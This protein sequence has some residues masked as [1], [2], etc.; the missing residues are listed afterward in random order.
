MALLVATSTDVEAQITVE[1]RILDVSSDV[2]DMDPVGPSDPMWLYQIADVPNTTT[3]NSSTFLNATNCP[4]TVNVNDLFFTTVYNCDAPTSFD[5][6]WQGYEQDGA[7]PHDA[8]TGPQVVNIP[9]GSLTFPQGAWTTIG[10]YNTTAAGTVGCPGVAGNVTW[11]VVLQYRTVGTLPP[12]QTNPTI[13]CPADQNVNLNASCLYSVVDF[14]GMAVTADACSPLVVTQDVAVGTN[15]AV[16]TTITLTVTDPT[17]NSNTCTFD[18]I[19]ADNTNP[20]I[21]C[22]G[23]V[24]V[25]NDPGV[26]NANV[27]VP[28]PATSDN[29]GVASVIN[30]YNSTASADDNYPVGTT[31]VTW[32]VTDVNGN[33][34]TCT[35]D[36]TV[37]DNENPTI[38]CDADVSVNNDPGV[39]NAAV[40]VGAPVATAD[41]CGIAS[42]LNDFNGTASANDTYPVGT[43]TVTWTITDVNGNTNTCTQ[44]VTVTDNENP[45][46]TCDADVTVNNDA[47][48]CNAVVAVPV[49]TA[50]GDNC[51]VATV[52]NDY[53]GTASAND[54]YPV[55]TTTV[56]WEVTDIH[57]NTQFCT[58]DVTV[59][60]AE[61]PTI[62]CDA[63]VTVNNDAGVCDAAV[64]VGAPVTTTD[65]CGV[66]TVL[67]DFNGTASANDT[68][69]VGTTTVT[70]TVTDVNGNTNTCTQ[71]VT[72]N[73]TE[74]P[75][76]TCSAD[77]TQTADPG[78]CNAA[79]I[80][81][82]PSATGD[83]CG[84]A[85]VIN[86]YN[87]TASADDTYP[88]GTTTVTWTVTDVNGNTNT[89]T[90]DVTVTDN[91][92]PTITCDADVTVNNDV[93][94]CNANVVVPPPVATG[95]NCG[96]ATVLN[97]YN[98]TASANDTYPVGTTTVTWEVTDLSGNTQFCTQDVTVNDTENPTITCDADVTV[99]NDVGVCNANV[100]VPPPIATG[101]NC[102]VATVLNDYNGTASANDTYPVGT[103]TVTWTVTDLSGNTNTCTQDV[104]V[105]D[106][107][108]PTITCS[109]DVTQTADPGVCNAAVIVP[110]PSATGDNCGVA[111]V[112]NDYNGTASAD[113][114]YP[115]GTTTVT[116][117][118]TDVNG[119]TNTCTQDVTV[120][121]N[122]NPTITCD[123]DV[124]VNN[125][126]GV[127]NAN[128][129]VP[130]P[131]ATGD[132]CGVATVLNDYNGTAS[133]NDNYPV[134]TT[135]V[136]WEVTDLSGNTQTCTQDVTVTDNENPT[137]TCAPD[138]AVNN[139]PGVCNAAVVVPGPTTS[140]NCGVATVI[141]DYNGTASADDTYPVG[142]TTVT[143]TV[144]D[145]HG[146]VNTCTQDVTVNDNEAPVVT[147]PGNVAQNTDAGVCTAVVNGIDMVATS[148]NC[149][150]ILQTWDLTGATVA[151]SPGAG[152][153]D[154]S[155]QTFNVGTTTV[156]YTIE[157]AVGNQTTCSFDVVITDNELP[158]I[159]CPGN[160]NTTA[161][162]G[163]CNT[164]VN[165]IAPV[166]TADNCG[167]VLQT[168]DLTGATVASSPGVGIN[169]ASGQTFNVG[170]TTVTYTVEDASGNSA[171]CSFDVTVTDTEIPSITCGANVTVN[172]D[173]GV[174]N[175]AVI[176]PAPATNDNCGVATVINDYNGTASAN[177]TYPVGTTTITW[178]VT[179]VNGNVNTCTQDVTVNDNENPTISC[180][181][182]VA[183]NID[184]GTCGAVVNVIAPTSTG[185]NCGIVTQTWDLTGATVASSPGAGIN[186][187]SGQTFNVGTTTVTYTVTDAAGNTATCSF[188]VVITDN[189]NPTITCPGNVAQNVDPGNCS[190]VVNA[191]APTATADNCGVIIQTWDLTGATV[192]SSPAAGI[193]DASGQTFNVGT[194]TVTYTV[195]DA[196]GN[197]A[198]CS[199]DVVIT[200]N[201]NPTI[202][203]PGNVN[204]NNDPGNCSAVVNGL[205]P[206]AT[207]DNCGITI[208]T[209][210]ITGVTTA[211]SPL[212][213]INDASGQTFNVGASVVTY[214]VEDAA[215]NTA[216]CNFTVTVF[217]NENPTIT[218]PANVNQG[219]DIGNCSAVVTGI[220]PVATNDNCG[221]IIQTWDLTGATVAS[222]PA[223][224]INDASGETF[225][226]GT[227][228]VTYTVEDAAGNTATCSFDVTITD[229]ENPTVVSCPANINQNADPGVCTATFDPVDP[230]FSDNCG[231][232]TVTWA[233]T[234]ASTGNS[235][236]GGIN[237]VGNTTYNL[238]TST[239]TYTV[240]DAVGNS[241]TCSFDI[242]II[243]A[244]APTITCPAN[245]TINND[246]GQCNAVV[247]G[248]GPIATGDNCGIDTQTWTLTGATTANSPATGINDASGQTFNLGTT[249]VTYTVTDA[250]GNATS[251]SF[252]ITIVDAENPVIVCPADITQPNNPGVCGRTITYAAPIGTDNC[253]GATTT[254]I[255]GLAS[256]SLF[257]IGTTVVTYEV[258]DAAGNTAQCSF[259]VTVNDTENPSISCPADITQ[260]SDPGICGATVTYVAPVGADNCPGAVTSLI[261]G[262][263]SGTIF[264]TGTTVV[265]Y[266]VVDA[267]GNTAQCSFNVTINDNED[268]TIACP[269]DITVSNDAGVCGA[270]VN[271]AAPVT[272]DNCPGETTTLIAGLA[273]GSV[274]PIGTTVVTYEV[275]DASGNTAQ[276]SFNVTVDD[277]ENPVINCPANI[278]QA[279][280][281]GLCGAIITYA[282][283]VGTD[284]CPG[285]VTTMTAGQASGTVFSVGTTTVTYQVTDASGNTAQCSFDV[286]VNDTQLPVINC[287][288]N[289]TQPNNPGVCGRT[290]TYG[291]PT[292]TDNC[293]G[294]V[295]TLTTGL[296]SGS[297]FPIG[298]TTVTYEVTDASGNT[299][300][301][302]FDVTINDTENP[303]ISCP[304]NITQAN[305]PGL[306]GAV[307]NY[308]TPVGADNCPGQT[309]TLIAGLASGSVFPV[310]TTTV[311]YEV[312]DASGN[313]AQCSFDV[314]VNDTENPTINCPADIV[315]SNDVGVCGAIVNY[316]TP[317]GADNCPGSV[318]TMTAGLATGSLFPIGTTV[319]TYQVT[320]ASGNTATCSFNVTVDD[321]E[322]PVIACP[323]DITQ[324]NDPALCGAVVTY[325]PPVGTDNCPGAVTTLI[326]GQAS[327]TV[328]PIGTTVVTY[329]VTDASGNTAQC[330]F[331]VTV[332]DTELPTITCPSNITQTN[333]PGVCGRT[334]SYGTPTGLDNCPGAT[335]T[336]IAGLASGSLF[337]IGTTTVTYEVTDA[338]GNTA[339]CSFD[340]TI[341]DTENPTIS[342]PANITQANDPAL[343]GAVVNYVTPVGADNC[344]GSVTSL[345]AGQASGTV[346]TV[347]TTTV[348]YEVID[349]SG[350]TAQC[351]FDITVQDTENPTINCPADIIVGNDA[352]V[353]GAIVNYATP[354]GLDNCPGS[355]TILTGGLA[356]GSLFPIGTTTVSYQVTDAS[357]NTANCSFDVTVDDTENPV[358]ACPANITQSNDPGLCGATVVYATPVGTDNCPGAVTVMTA[359]QASG[360]VFPI[361]TTTV[362]YQVTDASGNTTQCSFNV[363]VNDNENPVIVCPADMTV[364]NDPG[365]CGAIVNY[366]AP[367]GVDNCPGAATNL[368]AGLAPG[369][370]FPIGTTTVTYEVVDAA[371]NSAQCSFD[372]TVN[373]TEN[374][375]ISCPADITTN[376]ILNVCGAVV[377]YVTPVGTDNCPGAV[378]AMTT[379]LTSGALFPV[380]TTVVTYQVT[381]AAGN[382]AQCSFNVTVNDTQN[383]TITC[384]ANISVNN[385]PGVC[386]AIV[387]FVP[388]GGGDNCPGFTVNLIAGLPP[389]SLFPIGTTTVTYEVTDASGNTNQCSFDVTVNDNEFPVIT[390]PPNIIVNNDPGICGAVVNY[391]APVGTDNCPGAVTVLTAGL[392]PG[393][394]FP[395]GTTTVTYEVTD[396]SGN[397]S[398]CSFD[399]TVNDSEL[400]TI[401]CPAN[402][403]VSNDIGSCGAIVNYVTPVG[404]D[405]C[406]GSVTSLI[407]GLASGSFFPVGTTTVTYEVVDASGNTAQCSFDVTVQD[408]ENPAISCPPDITV[409]NDPGVCGAVVNYLAPT[410][411]DN[412]PGATTTL[413]AGQASGTLFPVGTTIV[414]Y[415]VTDAAGNSVTCSFNVIVND[416][417][418][419]IIACPGNINVFNDPGVCGANV[420]YIP[421]VGLDNCPGSVTTLI[422]GLPPGSFFPVGTTTITYEVVD[423][424]GN[425][426]QCSFDIIVTDN[427]PA[428]PT[429]PPDTTVYFDGACQ[430]LL[431]NYVPLT[432]A[433]DNCGVLSITQSPPPGTILLADQ[434]V[435]MT[436]TDVNGNVITC[437]FNVFVADSTSP[438]ISC[439][440]DQNV[441]FDASC[442]YILPDYTGL[443]L[444]G[445]N[446][447]AVT[448][449]QNPIAGTAI[450]DTTTITLTADDGNGNT[451]TCTFDVNPSDNIN[452]VITCPGDQNVA[453][454]ANCEYTLLDYTGL[455]IYSDNC[456]I[457]SVTQSL[458]AGTV[459][460]D[461]VTITITVL[462]AA[463]NSANCSFDVNPS[464]Q[465]IPTIACPPT[466]NVFFD[467]N[468][469]YTL[470]D[471]TTLP[472][473]SDNCGPLTVTQ[474]PAAGT[475][476]VVNTTVTLTVTDAAGNFS[477]CSFNVE[478]TD[479]IPPVVT[480][481]ADQIVSLSAFCDYTMPNMTPLAS[482][483][484]NCGIGSITQDIPVGTV[485]TNTTLVTI[486]ATDLEGNTDQCNFQV[487]PVDDTPPI[488]TCPGNQNV[489]FN[490]SCQYILLDYT[491][492]T[493]NSDN[494][495]PI[496]LNQTPAP[497]T[498]ITDTTT[499]TITATDAAGNVTSCNFDVNPSD[500]TPPVI[501]S[502]PPDQNEYVGISCKYTIP[503][504]TGLLTAVDNCGSYTVTQFPLGGT[505]ISNNTTITLTATDDNGNSS[506]CTFDVLLSDTISPTI[507]CPPAPVN[508][509]FDVNCE[510]IIVP[511]DSLTSPFDNCI[512]T[513]VSQVPPPGTAI[514]GNQTMTMIVTDASGN[515]GQCMFDLIPQD[516]IAPVI[517]CPGNQV[518]YLN[519]TCHA[520]I[521]DYTPLANTTANCE[522]VIVTQDP[523]AGT[524]VSGQ[525][526]IILY[527]E[528]ASGNQSFC[529]FNMT[530]TDTIDPVITCPP[531][532]A[533]CNNVVLFSIPT[534]TDNCGPVTVTRISGLPSGS[535]FP[536]GITTQTYVAEDAYG[537]TDTCSFIIEVYVKPEGVTAVTQISCYGESDGE[538][539]LEVIAG[540]PPFNY[541]W[542]NGA[543]T[544]DLTGLVEG[545]YTC[546]I[547]GNYGCSDT[548]T[549]DIIEP[550]SLWID[551]TITDI[552]CFGDGDGNVFVVVNGGT[553]PYSYTWSPTGAGNSAQNLTPGDYTLTV[554]DSRGCNVTETYTVNEPDSITINADISFYP[555]SGY[556]ISFE[557]GSDG[558][559]DLDVVGGNGPP[560]A[561]SWDNGET[562]DM[563]EDLMAGTYTVI[564]IDTNGCEQTGT[565]ILEEPLA[566][567][568]FTGL[569]PN[570][571]GYNDLWKILN[572]ERYP[573]NRLI[574]MNRWGNVVYEM[575][576]YAHT[577]GVWDD[578]ASWDGTPNKGIVMYGDKVPEGSYYFVFEAVKG[579]K[580]RYTGY[581]VVKY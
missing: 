149:G 176:V 113:D 480:C 389:G 10:T 144:T 151:S 448:V 247:N 370:F 413:I 12:D 520:V 551:E 323:P 32:T 1:F 78:V 117:T 30:D 495:G 340:V 479:P 556:E 79:V 178:T 315:V 298:T 37:T 72:V 76:I 552:T 467:A 391:L 432:S 154:A 503:D 437:D 416:T 235:P 74:A 540:N 481:P 152:I 252:D 524:V 232:V 134:G 483:T 547:T 39:C 156:T 138:V 165:G 197:T 394:L 566:P 399:V 424:S 216:T 224:G 579:G 148:D 522:A 169:D 348:T 541:S 473:V 290:V 124:T 23:N 447:G 273:S 209:W 281:V 563:I 397:V 175:A 204:V 215:G 487:I 289:I 509:Y 455:P 199:F 234:G 510:Y 535:T 459:I 499:I 291:T 570:G 88:V 386:G 186:D 345:I 542:S 38:T 236:G 371:G 512:T 112:I 454:D 430:H 84:V 378:T 523:P 451:S 153:N 576:S 374:P 402:I 132:N 308:V 446:C 287:P 349:A 258:T 126:V 387:N 155:G 395:I 434:L 515:T 352:G 431:G 529:T 307:V 127:C 115:V 170:T 116:W 221:I 125:D 55:G 336:L 166:A 555:E 173:P 578:N 525:T 254:M 558:W 410:G 56:T 223:V 20:S 257:P 45:T 276:C 3:Q 384:P 557:G 272:S 385:D 450:T 222:S 325:V 472:A 438:S 41:N 545:T 36:V 227:T 365:A 544:E 191:I 489:S 121:D 49:P 445:D 164:I 226:I 366:V 475:I 85:T 246:L 267:S 342:C 136:T 53:N 324:P 87:G 278:T 444:T 92:N 435:T 64:V 157:D 122:E 218:C 369:S 343:C 8:D 462:D 527:G 513:T 214:V 220:A 382:T 208:Q 404:L 334:V 212:T 265:T 423:P 283:P 42:V 310:G 139:D 573:D 118:V 27:V 326:A 108:A 93:G 268:P 182:N 269:A 231:V 15:I 184:A 468:C 354:V 574:I 286:T 51:G 436:V 508:V 383:P 194:T 256:G 210:D 5:F 46:I 288:G 427:E 99:N 172:N 549:I 263:A 300:Q 305:D 373:D 534:A 65:N 233:I 67:N 248:I 161:T 429:C 206:V 482:A 29:C 536:D 301:C 469:Q 356:S 249:T 559:I 388:P 360:T 476:I 330:S 180:P 560:Y 260:N 43:T 511:Y 353:C 202:T 129:V 372:I 11:E 490:N 428:M 359:G 13:T 86:D 61:N 147:C 142:T 203:C 100:V 217:D 103:T 316:V 449:T 331:N 90:Q 75:T 185:D 332:N 145:I 567:V 26:C 464:D 322:N 344:P 368:I 34:N 575:D 538:V 420:N 102:G 377:N 403:T 128:V 561:Y 4:G 293:P 304:A 211:S 96:V 335:T 14:T 312:T 143:W 554:V 94:V 319:V 167:I 133:A 362:T 35:Q 137:I 95:D 302:S 500:N 379:G 285:S 270:T 313:T 58:Q 381:D 565:Y 158:T 274:F 135:T 390:C 400:P 439:P 52:L 426:A 159:T 442:Q 306:C 146:N 417:E 50:S 412:C 309:T 409:S 243:D 478:P 407:A 314:T 21:T 320:D 16:T 494:C 440:V 376:N 71:D 465:S 91:E 200:D 474:S 66:A 106:N 183:Q 501:I 422:A 163:L 162:A 358:I 477:Q 22:A 296:A 245:A 350:N 119:N 262:Q 531:D 73:D 196:A 457:I 318:T 181:A 569:S 421:P 297:L 514:V 174:C 321:T 406:P 521:P 380:G 219:T 339:Q 363:T 470:L 517:G 506:Q 62:V 250:S 19:P 97:D 347:G 398:N 205:A 396:A 505:D 419:P 466:Q 57:G 2:G 80:V 150:V 229:N 564:V 240:L 546:V 562:T 253:P 131:V 177:D 101:D 275:T 443:A 207:N 539:D 225:N 497:G 498:A 581:I 408:T 98:G 492:M 140:D 338:S 83:N 375:V 292:G 259:N 264:P 189:E 201:E 295:T 179:D 7:G 418:L 238:G 193:N 346:F 460:T 568:F 311:T 40:V 228:T 355:V 484:D 504:Y 18:V 456:G 485:I 59:N 77:V 528:D 241:N 284:N 111:T 299:A 519:D 9:I 580:I 452:P 190:A 401:S 317:V 198:T 82:A 337:P 415:E 130:P 33:T 171:T 251:C 294:A 518:N 279:N 110:A 571:D 48:A 188:D 141:N 69:P 60:D 572:V 441:F 282:A 168:W 532:I 458:A 28:A 123:A 114:T 488:I 392:P 463:G 255:A 109:A 105:T 195:E 543:T 367:V 471:Y 414:T 266:E 280:D 526:T 303:T 329:Q 120:T 271:Y 17:G 107:E 237:F 230:V 496:V 507:T 327:G 357:G 333:D 328:F 550:D 24:S 187:A 486:T 530:L 44:D 70:W 351:S 453:F 6:T 361:G 104:T 516:T 341:N 277:T 364:S 393:S 493:A 31:T 25:N 502:C 160:V 405:N 54:T 89:C 68:Y 213:G 537:N 411:T 553:F 433:A 192:A 47:T 261:A 242:T 239:L 63:D 491:I 425:T 244:E 533:T 577:D 548:V 81:P 461:T